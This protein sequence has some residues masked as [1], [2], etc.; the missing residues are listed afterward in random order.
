[1]SNGRVAEISALF[2]DYETIFGAAVEAGC[3]G[4]IPRW[5]FGNAILTRLPVFS[6]FRH[7]LPQ[8]PEGGIRHMARQAIEVTLVS[9]LGPL[10]VIR[11]TRNSALRLLLR[12]T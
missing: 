2:P 12:G 8:P 10:R 3:D 1:M 4:A 11:T 6:V 7:P 9:N 5:Q